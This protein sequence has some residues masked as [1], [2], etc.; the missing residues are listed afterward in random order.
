[1]VSCSGFIQPLNLQCILVNAF[2]GSME[3]FMFIALMVIALLGALELERFA[4]ILK[5]QEKATTQKTQITPFAS[6]LV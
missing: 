6:V 2:A 4:K 1:M 3:I 5:K